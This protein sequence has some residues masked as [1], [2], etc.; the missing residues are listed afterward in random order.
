MGSGALSVLFL[1][2]LQ[3]LDQFLAYSIL[4]GKENLELGAVRDEQ[5]LVL[6]QKSLR[7]DTCSNLI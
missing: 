7:W 3:H 2:N 4:D 5:G 1:V 6:H